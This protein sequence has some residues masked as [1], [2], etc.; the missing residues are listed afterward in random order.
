MVSFLMNCPQCGV[1][2]P[3][4]RPCPDCHWS[5]RD[6]GTAVSDQSI[7]R[8]FARRLRKHSRNYAIFMMLMFASGLVSLLTA[9]MWCLVIYRGSTGAFLLVGVLTV[10]TGILNALLYCS[11]KLFPVDVLCPACDLHLQDPSLVDHDCPSCGAL[12]RS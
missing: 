5:D 12:L 6:E 11:K 10:A 4:D 3:K 7:V 9:V 2:I 1:M 8:E